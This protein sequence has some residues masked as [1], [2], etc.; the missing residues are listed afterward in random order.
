MN[1]RIL[2]AEDNSTNQ[3]VAIGLLNKLGLHA[4][5]V[6]D[7][8]EVLTALG[9]LPYDLVLMDVQMPVMDGIE[10]TRQIRSPGSA[11][12][13]HWIPIIAMTAHALQGD[14]E[15]FLEAGMNDYVSKPV[16]APDLVKVLKCWLPREHDRVGTLCGCRT[17]T[18][19]LFRPAQL[20]YDREGMLDRVL[21][22]EELAQILV[23]VFL[24]DTPVQ[25]DILRRCLAECDAGGTER[26]AH[27][28]KT[29]AA[30][31]GGV[32]LSTLAC[33]MEKAASAGDLDSVAARLPDLELQFLMLKGA[34]LK[35]RA[36]SE[37]RQARNA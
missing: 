35:N 6:A 31:V 32:V 5:A 13:N 34:I 2:V 37:I 24:E 4:D 14:R 25:I 28:L 18:A 36:E 33:E 29:A 8:V 19:S 12:L 30:Y 1:A 21:Q 9:S 7:G 27:S 10:A 17:S 26:Q 11:V 20:V 16:A 23:A 3:V 15:R 22:D